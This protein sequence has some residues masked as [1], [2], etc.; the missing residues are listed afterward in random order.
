MINIKDLFIYKYGYLYWKQT[1]SNRAIKNTIAGTLKQNKYWEIQYKKK[2]YY[3]HRLIW[4]LFNGKIPDD[5]VIDHI[6]GNPTDNHIENLRC[7]NHN[8]NL[9]NTHPRITNKS[10]YL[11]ISWDKKQHK[12]VAALS[13]KGK[14]IFRKY[15]ND[16]EQAIIE[17]NKEREVRLNVN[18]KC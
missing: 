18:S 10:G 16:I 2:R 12:W 13:Y 5:M 9:L 6:N 4:E 3:A 17:L 11:G 14:R 8:Q 7:V 15:Y 1:V